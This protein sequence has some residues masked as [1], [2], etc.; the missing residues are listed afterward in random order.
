MHRRADPG[1]LL[2]ESS[3]ATGKDT[4]LLAS[5]GDSVGRSAA[6]I[7]PVPTADMG[8]D[9]TLRNAGRPV[10]TAQG[11][12]A[13]ETRPGAAPHA[14]L[15]D[16]VLSSIR[17]CTAEEYVPPGA[18][19]AVP[20]PGQGSRGPAAPVPSGMGQVLSSMVLSGQ[21]P[22]PGGEMLLLQDG[23]C[24]AGRDARAPRPGYWRIVPEYIGNTR[25]TR[26]MVSC[27]TGR[28]TEMMD[29]AV[30][31]DANCIRALVPYQGRL[32]DESGTTALMFAAEKGLDAV[33]CLLK[34]VEMGMAD[35][36]GETALM[37]AAKSNRAST[38]ELLVDEAGRRTGPDHPAGEGLTALCLACMS[39]AI[40]C[41][42]VLLGREAR[43]GYSPSTAPA[44][45]SSTAE[46]RH[47]VQLYT[48]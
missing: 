40:D 5:G 8:R 26:Q 31:N 1:A 19:C 32:Q 10:H 24:S 7:T 2:A 16:S 47:L 21:F 22:Q 35:I 46:I 23:L 12:G 27:T 14:A 45:V 6:Q 39:G 43:L 33:V 20:G 3:A 42:R 4:L 36:H 48:S 41:V 28:F 37:R 38:C 15:E 18:P 34:G 13:L 25:F 44:A 29:A 9:R 17:R 11:P 30:R